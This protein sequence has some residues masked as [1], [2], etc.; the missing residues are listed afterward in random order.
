VY[1]FRGRD[2]ERKRWLAGK[3]YLVCP[4]HGRFGS[5]GAAAM[6]EY[7]LENSTL[8]SPEKPGAPAV[9]PEN[10]PSDP[11]PNPEKP[12]TRAPSQ[13]P[14]ARPKSRDVWDL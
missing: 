4:K 1:R 11:S 10:N 8:W 5:D 6:Q 9:A 13:T 7:I 3:L 2:D 14:P 12:T